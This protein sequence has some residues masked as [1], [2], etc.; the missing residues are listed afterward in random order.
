MLITNFRNKN[1]EI[2]TKALNLYQKETGDKSLYIDRNVYVSGGRKDESMSALR[3]KGSGM[4]TEFWEIFHRL[5]Q[6]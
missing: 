5:E 2:Y 3:Y 1:L 4:L 6:K